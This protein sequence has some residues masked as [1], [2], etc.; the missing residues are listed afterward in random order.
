[1]V[2]EGRDGEEIGR[3]CGFIGHLMNCK[4]KSLNSVGEKSA[5]VCAKKGGP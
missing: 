2:E 4:K 5:N 1:M 3:V